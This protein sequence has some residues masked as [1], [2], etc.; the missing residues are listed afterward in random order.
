MVSTK[1]EVSDYEILGKIEESDHEIVVLRFPSWQTS[2]S[3]A[4]TS[5]FPNA[6]LAD[7][8]LYFVKGIAKFVR[9]RRLGLSASRSNCNR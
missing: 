5:L 3:Q 2:L 9:Q 1:S 7:K 8:L 4:L 6:F